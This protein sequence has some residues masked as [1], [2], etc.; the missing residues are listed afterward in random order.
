MEMQRNRTVDC[1]FAST[2]LVRRDTSDEDCSDGECGDNGLVRHGL[3][4][5]RQERFWL[6]RKDVRMRYCG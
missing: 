1:G 5:F 3:D 4:R 2:G 6:H